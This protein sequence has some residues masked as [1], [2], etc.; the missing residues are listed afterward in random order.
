MKNRLYFFRFVLV[1]AMGLGCLSASHAAL[2]EDEEARRAILDLRQKLEKQA[3]TLQQ[4]QRAM[5][6]QQNQFELLRSEIAK[7]RGEKEQ[8]M[9][10]IKRQQDIAQGVDERLRKFEPIK[11]NV[12][13]V[14]FLADPAET[15]AY[16]DALAFFKTGDFANAA[17]SF[18]EFV[19]RFPRSGYGVPSLFW[20]GNAQYATRDYK[21]AI[22]NFSTLLSRAPNHMRAPDSLLSVANSQLELKDLK[23]ARKTLADVVKTYPNSE[24]ASAANERLAKLK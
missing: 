3:E 14:E 10:D 16:E 12:D 20:L 19:R 7:L 24:A 1:M 9:L 15:K 6:E 11:V 4:F 23:A 8:L 18:A 22:K 17:T 5:L 2:F 21:E 13:G